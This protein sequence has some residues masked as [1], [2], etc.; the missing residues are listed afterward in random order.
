MCLHCLFITTISEG[1]MGRR[2]DSQG[3][4]DRSKDF[5]FTSDT[6]KSG[7]GQLLIA[8]RGGWRLPLFFL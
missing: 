8:K 3:P 6:K 2:E 5:K 4:E 7:S 1:Y